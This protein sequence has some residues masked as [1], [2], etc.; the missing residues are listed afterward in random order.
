MCL[1]LLDKVKE[2]ERTKEKEKEKRNS[3]EDGRWRGVCLDFFPC[4]RKSVWPITKCQP[5]E[6][7]SGGR[8]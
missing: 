8:A 4:H 1:F 2:R 6:D 3:G 5:N 7:G